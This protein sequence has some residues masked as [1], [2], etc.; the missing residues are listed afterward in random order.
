[1][2][3]LEMSSCNDGDL[4]NLRKYAVNHNGSYYDVW[5]GWVTENQNHYRAE[6]YAHGM[7]FKLF[8]HE[9]SWIVQRQIQHF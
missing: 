7:S 5:E 1:M 6:Y 9:K 8:R 3:F 4:F 2:G